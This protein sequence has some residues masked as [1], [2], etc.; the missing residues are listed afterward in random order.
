ML[1][2]ETIAPQRKKK[3]IKHNYNSANQTEDYTS[4]SCC[5]HSNGIELHQTKHQEHLQ[6]LSQNTK[7]QTTKKRKKP[8]KSQSHIRWSHK[9]V[10]NILYCKIERSMFDFFIFFYC[11]GNEK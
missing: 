2:S 9:N 6:L 4:V 10:Q 8:Y 11:Y 7:N 5:Y 3:I 1:I